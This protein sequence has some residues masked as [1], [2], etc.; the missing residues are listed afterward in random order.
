MTASELLVFGITGAS[1]S[2]K[3]YVSDIFRSLGVVVFDADEIG[4][5]VCEPDGAAY[6]ELRAHFGDDFF[7]ED[8]SLDRR[9]L[10]KK[11]FSEPCELDILNKITHKHIKEELARGILACTGA[12][13]IDGAVIIG[14]DVEGLCSFLV[15]VTAPEKIR[16]K[17][18]MKRDNISPE[19]AVARI[20]AQP[21]EAFYRA[22]CRYIIENANACRTQLLRY[23]ENILEENMPRGEKR[24]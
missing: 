9:K 6:D 12:A 18:I 13:A 2:G 1:G 15:G 19:E 5:R 3:S 24:N 8:G 17:R 22:H 16:L 20:S 10:A 11:V 21:D 7:R 23:A 4:H 14:S